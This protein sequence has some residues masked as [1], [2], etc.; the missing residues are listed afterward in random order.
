MMRGWVLAGLLGCGAQATTTPV[1]P[2]PTSGGLA[3]R[4]TDAPIAMGRYDATLL[5]PQDAELHVG[6]GEDGRFVSEGL[7][8]GR[9]R[10]VITS[11]IGVAETELE[12][13][14]GETTR[15]ELP[16]LRFAYVEGV[17]MDRVTHMGMPSVVVTSTPEDGKLSP[18]CPGYAVT[19]FGGRFHLRV[20]P[21]RLKV[22][23]SAAP[24][25]NPATGLLATA[26]VEVGPGATVTIPALEALSIARLADASE[27]GYLGLGT[28]WGTATAHGP[29]VK[30]S[31]V[32]AEHLHKLWIDHVTPGSPAEQGGLRVGDRVLAV[33]GREIG[34]DAYDAQMVQ[35]MIGR[36]GVRVGQRLALR[37]RRGEAVVE[38]VL[39]AVR[40]ASGGAS[41]P[42]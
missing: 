29:A 14:S 9:Y 7:P 18:S 15:A 4:V 27:V 5:G 17:V 11:P 39:V 8:A 19:P 24:D 32:P 33:D 38:L 25:V 16:L 1:S 28:V 40:P 10:L 20:C 37:V 42:P 35:R 41:G 6:D 26:S 31:E 34:P 13:R 2:R 22:V 21:G 3:V 23:V 36:G 12:V 30:R